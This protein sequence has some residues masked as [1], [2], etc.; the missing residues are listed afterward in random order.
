MSSFNMHIAVSKKIKEEFSFG[1][2]FIL[3]TVL[4]DLYKV[5]LKD[6]ILTHFERKI[7]EEYLPDIEK[8]CDEYKNK[9]SEI[10]YGYLAHLVEDRIWFSQYN[11]QYVQQLENEKYY[12]YNKDN[13]IHKEE[14]YL[15]D[16]YTD[17][18]IIDKY[19]EKEYNLNKREINE[20]LKSIIINSKDIK[21]KE[22]LINIIDTRMIDYSC[23][24]DINKPITFF[25]KEQA[26]EYYIKAVEETKKVLDKF[27][28]KNMNSN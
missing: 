11:N 9:K 3:G 14:E 4:P 16:I 13:T 27:I 17:Y 12:K 28:N 8:F 7:G 1:D 2:E 21:E 5:L 20:K 23:K 10:V 18:T 26:N 15:T 19:L 22:E 24:Y 25:T 6:R